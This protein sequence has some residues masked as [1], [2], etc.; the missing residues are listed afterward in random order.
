M[1][2]GLSAL[3]ILASAEYALTKL[4]WLLSR[5]PVLFMNT[6]TEPFLR[7]AAA[8]KLEHDEERPPPPRVRT[9]VMRG[10]MNTG[11]NVITAELRANL[12]D[13]G[14]DPPSGIPSPFGCNKH[15]P[16]QLLFD[17]FEPPKVQD[18]YFTIITLRHPIAWM[19]S[20]RKAHYAIQCKDWCAF[21]RCAL[22]TF[23]WGAYRACAQPRM[24]LEYG[25]LEDMWIE[26]AESAS[27]FHT[28][29]VLVRYEDFLLD[30]QDLIRAVG[31][32]ARSRVREGLPVVVEDNAKQQPWHRGSH[33]RAA[34][35]EGLWNATIPTLLGYPAE[36]AGAVADE[37]LL[38]CWSKPAPGAADG[39]D[40]VRGDPALA[41]RLA[42]RL[43]RNS[44]LQRLCDRFGYRC[45]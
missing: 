25:K 2:T 35:L 38:G 31:I 23:S 18:A 45:R 15:T 27:R 6:T 9:L 43:A 7:T 22:P 33:G 14:F 36:G 37:A 21:A 19:V 40:D 34:A 8:W 3:V 5:A 41:A 39:G 16:L 44:A 1:A 24:E 17:V 4:P 12:L 20:M 32:A 10:Q 13:T 42:R 26:W 29:H 30:S 28:P 11:T